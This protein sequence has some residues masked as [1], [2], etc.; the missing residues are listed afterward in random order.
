M[1]NPNMN[2]SGLNLNMNIN[3]MIHNAPS[4]I[5]VDEHEKIMAR[6]H[7]YAD[8]DE[9]LDFMVLYKKYKVV[10]ACLDESE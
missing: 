5:S 7:K 4:Q 8:L 6:I 9:V 2:R 3:S 10:L 1:A